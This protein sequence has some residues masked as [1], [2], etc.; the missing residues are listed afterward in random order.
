MNLYLEN[1]SNKCYIC[2][3]NKNNIIKCEIIDNDFTINNKVIHHFCKKCLDNYISYDDFM[4]Y[5]SEAKLKEA[6][7]IR[8]EGKEYHP[9]DGDIMFFRANTSNLKKK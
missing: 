2:L 3:E 6:G 7:K 9:K 1:N 8:L 4:E 5:Q